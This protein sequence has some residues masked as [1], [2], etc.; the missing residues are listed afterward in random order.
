MGW[1]QVVCGLRC[2]VLQAQVM[3][4][5]RRG[6]SWAAL[7]TCW[8]PSSVLVCSGLSP[9]PAVLQSVLSVGWAIIQSVKS[10][11]ADRGTCGP[12]GRSQE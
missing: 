12:E 7:V 10:P 5:G 6:H 9:L 2:E 11:G 1:G 4:Q 3:A 8:G